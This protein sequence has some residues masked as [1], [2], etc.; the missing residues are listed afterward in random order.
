MKLKRLETCRDEKAQKPTRKART[1]AGN[2]MGQGKQRAQAQ[3]I[4]IGD[5]GT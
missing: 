4:S 3:Y 5:E 2:L 1:S